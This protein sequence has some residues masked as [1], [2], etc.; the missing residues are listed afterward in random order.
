MEPGGDGSPTWSH[1]QVFP[2]SV[3]GGSPRGATAGSGRSQ[4][5][6]DSE[7][8]SVG[9]AVEVTD[10]TVVEPIETLK[11]PETIGDAIGDATRDAIGD[12]GPQSL[13]GAR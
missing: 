9:S 8:E 11:T 1:P 2:G 12:A 10:S 3:P 5:R 13:P 4:L 7:V 6:F